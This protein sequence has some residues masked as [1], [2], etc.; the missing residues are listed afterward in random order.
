MEL[1]AV[2]VV[3]A[4]MKGEDT[5]TEKTVVKKPSSKVEAVSKNSNLDSIEKDK[6]KNEKEATERQISKAIEHVKSLQNMRTHCEF[7]YHENIN[8]ISIKVVDE[9]TGEVIREIPPEDSL[10]LV[11]KMWELAGILVDKK[12]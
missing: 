11:E 9:G 6:D 8:R 12:I 7:S 1:E 3:S 10:K 5:V 4:Q 2:K